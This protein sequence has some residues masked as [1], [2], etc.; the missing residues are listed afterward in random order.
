ML[1][2]STTQQQSEALKNTLKHS[3]AFRSA[4]SQ[5]CLEALK[6]TFKVSVALK[7]AQQLS[8]IL[9]KSQQVSVTSQKHPLA[10]KNTQQCFA[11]LKNKSLANL[12]MLANTD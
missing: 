5:K 2:S 9:S 10:L 11:P 1:S 12:M 7:I 4:Q 3:R 8:K 6:N